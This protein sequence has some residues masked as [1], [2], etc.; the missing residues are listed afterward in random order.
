MTDFWQG[1]P[2]SSTANNTQFSKKQPEM[3][4]FSFIHSFAIA[5]LHPLQ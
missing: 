4:I 1:L 2:Y 5:N 3:T